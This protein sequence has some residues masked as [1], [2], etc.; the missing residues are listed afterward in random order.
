MIVRIFDK[1]SLDKYKLLCSQLT[2]IKLKIKTSTK[3]F[4][5][6]LIQGDFYLTHYR[7][8]T[9][10]EMTLIDETLYKINVV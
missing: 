7:K 5:E 2:E 6:Q 9:D 8:L 10:D 3:I 1:N 4:N